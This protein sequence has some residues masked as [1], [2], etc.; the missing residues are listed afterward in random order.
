MEQA[1]KLYG[2]A[3][4]AAEANLESSRGDAGVLS[5]RVSHTVALPFHILTLAELAD[6]CG[7]LASAE[8]Q[9]RRRCAANLDRKPKELQHLQ[10]LLGNKWR[11]R[12]PA[13][14]SC[15]TTAG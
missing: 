8:C 3:A 1:T 14:R 4:V 5:S 6:S 13:T 9:Q 12:C 11:R 10:L 2:S 7:T 15:C